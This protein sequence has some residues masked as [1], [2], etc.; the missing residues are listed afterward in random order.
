MRKLIIT[1]LLPVFMISVGKAKT[2]G[3]GKT[4]ISEKTQTKVI[5]K[6]V[7]QYGDQEKSR[8]NSGVR[9]VADLWRETEG[10]AADFKS[11]CINNFAP[12]G[13]EQEQMFQK[14]SRNME[15]LWGKFHEI[16]VLLK[17]PLQL[18]GAAP[19]RIDR[20]FGGFDASAHLTEDLYQNKIA[21]MAA[22]N[23][24]YYTLEEKADKGADWSR[25]E[26]AYARMGDLFTSRVPAD[27]KQEVSMTLTEADS[28]ISEYNIYMGQL[29]DEQMETHFPKDMKL[30][31]HWGLRDELKS[32]YADKKVGLEKQEMIYS[33]MKRIIDQSIPE[34]VIN[35]DKCR[36]N[37]ENNTLYENGRE[38]NIEPEPNTR[39]KTLLANLEVM[40]KADAFY[41]NYESFIQRKFEGDYEIA[42]QQVEKMFREFVSSPVIRKTGKLISER[43]GRNLRPF[44]IWYDG[45][46]AR[47]GISEE[48]LDKILHEKYPTPAAFEK[49]LPRMLRE[50]GF[51]PGKAENI[52]SK[53]VV[54]PAR[55]A[56]HAWGAE[57]RSDVA[58][59]RTRVGENGMNYKGY[60][61]AVHEFGHNVE[62]T[63]SLH[64]VDYYM[65]NG[66]PNTAFTEALAFI[67]QK[68]DLKL[69]GM[70]GNNPDKKH[71]QV[72]DKL[73]SVY[74]I[75]GVSLV[76]MNV[77][78]WMYEH[79]EAD[80]TELKKAVIRIAREVWNEYYA[81]IFGSRNE[82]ILAVYS[83]MIDNPLYLS[84]YPLGM[85]VEFQ[86]EQHLEGKDFAKEV[87]RI[88]SQGRLIP[89]VWMKQAVDEEM[90][91]KPLIKASEKAV[92]AL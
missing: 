64:D 38:V 8:I 82:P 60:N 9:Q 2:T 78:K 74:E 11:F 63:I 19:T 75:M 23:F 35:N 72:L 4:M 68:R 20:M 29:V 73:W 12:Q 77:W 1:L 87:Q 46:K 88:Y 58:H 22:L 55:G 21:L 16:D 17:E 6:L 25:K 54:D 69:L 76:D 42:Q 31:T 28:Y 13:T 79:P 15:V 33:V 80:A 59:L 10:T 41:P 61:I 71:L 90:S 67:F 65:L 81:D 43:L 83:H 27:I 44:D 14:L 39:Y 47:S 45:F 84:A 53:V 52:S 32:Q 62:Q 3:M 85:L 30:I 7:D 51:S 5:S 92:E 70:E 56:G 34:E 57:M 89:Q 26:W 66:V 24:P 40:K 36:W 48:K 91:I 18:K 49:D 86:V 37:P 50:L